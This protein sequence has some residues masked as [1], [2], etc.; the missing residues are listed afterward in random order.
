MSEPRTPY[1]YRSA[2]SRMPSV[3][4]AVKEHVAALDAIAQ[5]IERTTESTMLLS[6]NVRA[7]LRLR[8]EE[9]RALGTALVSVLRAEP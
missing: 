4:R 7:A 5:N 2:L 3:E 1:P 6:P 8:V 9:L